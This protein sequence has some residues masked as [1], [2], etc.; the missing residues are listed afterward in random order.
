[1]PD[2]NKDKFPEDTPK[3]RSYPIPSVIEDLSEWP[4]YKMYQD[5]DSFMKD[6]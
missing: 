4:I 5:R 1:M 6:V 2:L 3:P